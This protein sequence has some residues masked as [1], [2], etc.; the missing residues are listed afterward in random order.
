MSHPAHVQKWLDSTPVVVPRELLSVVINDA[1]AALKTYDPAVDQPDDVKRKDREYRIGLVALLNAH[2][3]ELKPEEAVG[4]CGGPGVE[5][6][7]GGLN[8][9]QQAMDCLELLSRNSGGHNSELEGARELLQQIYND[10]T[11]PASDARTIRIAVVP[12]AA[13]VGEPADAVDY[14]DVTPQE[15]DELLNLRDSA[16]PSRGYIYGRATSRCVVRQADQ[17]FILEKLAAWREAPKDFPAEQYHEFVEQTLWR[18]SKLLAIIHGIPL[19]K[20][21][22]DGKGPEMPPDSF[23]GKLLKYIT[24]NNIRMRDLTQQSIQ[25]AMKCQANMT[26]R[27]DFF[28]MEYVKLAYANPDQCGALRNETWAAQKADELIASLSV[29]IHETPPRT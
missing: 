3:R 20:V 22:A 2:A 21:F 19:D 7:P 11:A 29:E 25:Q 23:E 26:T 10:A 16:E 13:R 6:T 5:Q 24:A 17:A 27:R 12:A 18:Q 1:A 28:V 15:F 9:L 8:K 4:N 14:I